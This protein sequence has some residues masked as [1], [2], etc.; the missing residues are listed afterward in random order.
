MLVRRRLTAGFSTWE[1][2]ASKFPPASYKKATGF[3][4]KG[5]PPGR[6]IRVG[7]YR[8]EHSKSRVRRTIVGTVPEISPPCGGALSM[9][10]TARSWTLG[11]YRTS[12]QTRVGRYGAITP[13]S[14]STSVLLVLAVAAA[15][16]E[17]LQHPYERSV[18]GIAPRST[19]GTEARTTVGSLGT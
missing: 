2:A 4:G 9:R 15:G 8:T 13:S 6:S 18:P 14:T 12:H 11:Q 17:V 16:T 5:D 10:S 1:S 3:R 19:A 7:Q